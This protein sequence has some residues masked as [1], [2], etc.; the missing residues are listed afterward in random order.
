MELIKA[1]GFGGADWIP[2]P[3]TEGGMA[4]AVSG[5]SDDDVCA[6]LTVLATVGLSAFE[7]RDETGRWIRAVC[8]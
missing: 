3:A 5:D 1:A 7:Y 8:R 4:L 6:V 2:D